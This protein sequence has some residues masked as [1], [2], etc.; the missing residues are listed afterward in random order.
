MTDMSG[1]SVLVTGASRGIGAATARA[2]A[3]AGAAV[4]LAAR[5]TAEI[6]AVAHDI[7]AGGGRARALACDVADRGAVAQAIATAEA[8]HGPLDIL[9][10]NA[11]MIE[12]IGPLAETDPDAWTRAID[13]NLKGVYYA[14]RAALPGMIARG[15]GTIITVSSGAASRPLDGWSSYCTSKAAAAMLTRAGALEAGPHGVRV[16]GLSPGTV[17]TEMQRVIKASGINRVSQL[18]WSEHIPADWPAR[19]LVWLAGPE[20][21]A[22]AGEEVSLRDED[23][24]RRV[25]LID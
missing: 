23:I 4:A 6:E 3:A 15:T 24:R 20:G 19:A 16:L 25:G 21:A 11:G 7:S 1:K 8:A 2:F 14:M 9:I 12:P 13:V 10:N 22:F 17:A 5:S 18:D